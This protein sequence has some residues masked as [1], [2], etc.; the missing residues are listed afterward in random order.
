MYLFFEITSIGPRPFYRQESQ[1][2]VRSSNLPKDRHT[3]SSRQSWD[4]NPGLLRPGPFSLLSLVLL[5]YRRS[6]N[7]KAIVSLSVIRVANV[8][9]CSLLAF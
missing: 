1:G 3:A 7:S 9:T 5:I 6:L 8:S 4:L 2:L